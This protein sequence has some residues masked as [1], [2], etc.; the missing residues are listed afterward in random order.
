[1]HDSTKYF[2]Y[3]L[4]ALLEYLTRIAGSKSGS[5]DFPE[6][7]PSTRSN[8][9]SSVSEVTDYHCYESSGSSMDATNA[10]T[11]TRYWSG[12]F[13]FKD[14]D[15]SVG[16]GGDSDATK[17]SAS[18]GSLVRLFCDYHGHSRQKNLF[19]YGCS[20]KLSWWSDDRVNEDSAYL[21]VSERR[22]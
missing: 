18:D 21:T 11:C 15:E 9:S 14:G 12:S 19:L 2:S 1:M 7:A 17:P 6:P 3:Y 20:N 16:G 8:N 4:Q 10:S 13:N 22:C 5:T